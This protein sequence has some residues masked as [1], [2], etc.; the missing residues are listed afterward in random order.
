MGRLCREGWGKGKGGC[1]DR[2]VREAES[3][4]PRR[5]SR[6]LSEFGWVEQEWGGRGEGGKDGAGRR[7]AGNREA[8]LLQGRRLH[9][10]PEAKST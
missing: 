9:R 3:T 2:R 1:R 8:R 7:R 4:W 6:S 5:A 10:V